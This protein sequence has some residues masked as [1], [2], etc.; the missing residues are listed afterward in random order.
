MREKEGFIDES[1][2]KWGRDTIGS[3]PGWGDMR[4]EQKM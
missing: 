1:K 3:V 4:E 2:D